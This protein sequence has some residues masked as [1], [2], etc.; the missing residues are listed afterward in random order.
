VASLA[1]DPSLEDNAHGNAEVGAKRKGTS[2]SRQKSGAA[3]GG[4]LQ[5][6]KGESQ[7]LTAGKKEALNVA[8]RFELKRKSKLST[9]RSQMNTRKR[10]TNGK[11]RLDG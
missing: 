8:Y 6:I 3:K 9:L 1:P 4:S 2:S 7:S 11:V 5:Q 10:R